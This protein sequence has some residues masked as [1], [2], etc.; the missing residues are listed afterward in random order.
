MGEIVG[1]FIRVITNSGIVDFHQFTVHICVR[2]ST[3]DH[4]IFH[5]QI[6]DEL[7]YQSDWVRIKNSYKLMSPRKACDGENLIFVEFVSIYGIKLNRF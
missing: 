1:Q 3:L 6:G 7:S 4:N 5:P 2:C